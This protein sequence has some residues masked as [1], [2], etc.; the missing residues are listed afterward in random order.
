VARKYWSSHRQPR[1]RFHHISTDE[2][3][4]SLGETGYFTENS[5]YAPNSPYSAS[6]ASSDMMVR[7]YYKTY[8]M[9]TVIT[10]CSN[11]YG[12]GQHQEKLI[13][14]I[15]RKALSR[16]PIPIYG[17][18]TNIRDWLHVTDH[19][20]GIDLAFHRGQAGETYAL[21]GNHELDN[22]TVATM[23]CDILDDVSKL[24]KPEH[25]IGHP[26]TYQELITFVTDRLGHDYRYAIHAGKAKQELDWSPQI[27]F[28]EGL[29]ETVLWYKERL[30]P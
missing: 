16:E 11:N 29:R 25:P 13:P 6:K 23:I 10:N 15:I 12:P 17:T 4:G 7:S 30:R 14:T 24:E 5:P 20:R 1:N 18:G 27:K 19:C 22:L 9:N 26:L 28:E 3:Y 21:G 2:V 8:G